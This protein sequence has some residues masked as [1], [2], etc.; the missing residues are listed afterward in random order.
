MYGMDVTGSSS[1][2]NEKQ[3]SRKKEP[4]P[5]SYVPKT[6]QTTVAPNAAD[7]LNSLFTGASKASD[8]NTLLYGKQDLSSYFGNQGV[9]SSGNT[10]TTSK[11]NNST[12]GGGITSAFDYSSLFSTMSPAKLQ[13]YFFKQI[14][15]CNILSKF[16]LKIFRKCLQ[17]SLKENILIHWL[18]PL[19]LQT[20]CTC[21]HL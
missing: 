15:T 21:L 18:K 10:Q 7:M 20:I 16:L 13:V 4:K 17:C 2:N 9:S 1:G 19:S 6:S 11:I 8:I 12:S 3:S 5:S 14:V